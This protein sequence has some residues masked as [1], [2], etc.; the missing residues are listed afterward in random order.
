MQPLCRVSIYLYLVLP[1]IVT[2]YELI[3][4]ISAYMCKKPSHRWVKEYMQKKILI[5]V[6]FAWQNEKSAIAWV[7][8]TGLV[9]MQN[10]VCA[11]HRL[12]C[13]TIK[14][15]DSNP[16]GFLNYSVEWKTE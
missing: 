5:T 13:S 6:F 15:C 8:I 9:G 14:Q 7:S 11:H 1:S 4:L 12:L 2:A 10:V 3:M 16:S